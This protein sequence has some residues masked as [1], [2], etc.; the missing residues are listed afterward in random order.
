GPLAVR[1]KTAF[2]ELAALAIAADESSSIEHESDTGSAPSS[3]LL[4][5]L[6]RALDR[7]LVALERKDRARFQQDDA[8]SQSAFDGEV[9]RLE[10]LARAG[11]LPVIRTAI[12]H[13]DF[14]KGGDPRVRAAWTREL[15]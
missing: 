3:A 10:H 15:K 12:V 9:G 1:V 5:H 2:P 8:L 4:A 14:A 7:K 6:I 11:L 13:L